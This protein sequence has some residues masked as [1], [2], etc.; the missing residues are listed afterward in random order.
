M[1]HLKKKTRG[2]VRKCCKALNGGLTP[3]LLFFGYVQ[4][5]NI[6]KYGGSVNGQLSGTQTKGGGG[7]GADW[8]M[9]TKSIF[10]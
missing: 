4:E 5:K 6:F 8:R 9:S 10:S 7:W 1:K 2:Y 3:F